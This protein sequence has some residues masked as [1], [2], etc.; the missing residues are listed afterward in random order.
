[1]SDQSVLVVDDNEAVRLVASE[2][3]KRLEF[4]VTCVGSG[5]EALATLQETSFDI[6]LLDIGMPEMSGI[7]AYDHLREFAPV[8]NV[9]FMTGYSKEE[10]T[11]LDDER[12]WIL[13][14]PFTMDDLTKVLADV[15]LS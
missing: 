1:M 6:V 13:P 8:Q 10:I 2:M 12:T 9:V 7:E 14:K 4:D 5:P 15:S 3:L 11:G